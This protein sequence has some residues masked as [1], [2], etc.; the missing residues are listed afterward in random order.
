MFVE[1]K[2]KE[3]AEKRIKAGNLNNKD[4]DIITEWK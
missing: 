4:L 3:A 1:L 2:L